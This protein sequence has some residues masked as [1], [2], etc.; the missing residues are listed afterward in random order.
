MIEIDYRPRGVCSQLIH[1][2]LDDAGTTI[3][4]VAFLGGCA[5]NLQAI[6]KLIKGR[7][8][9]ETVA[10]LEGNT[11]G[12]RPTSCADQLTHALRAAQARAAEATA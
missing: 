9:D 2:E 4:N 10:L 8:V 5:G 12:P 3:Q 7:P 1:V 6:S 11:C